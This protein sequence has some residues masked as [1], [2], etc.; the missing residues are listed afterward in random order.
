M[1]ENQPTT[2]SAGSQL[3]RVTSNSR[4]IVT[5]LL[6]GVASWLLYLSLLEVADTLLW[7]PLLERGYASLASL[8]P[9]AIVVVAYATMG[10]WLAAWGIR[11]SWWVLWL[12]FVAGIVICISA[13]ATLQSV[14][15]ETML[16]ISVFSAF[17]TAAVTSGV[18]MLLASRLMITRSNKSR[19]R[20]RE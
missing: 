11:P 12:A 20:T 10:R 17:V 6:S 14:H 1:H 19:E 15:L 5:S 8:L 18:A 4:A 3:E 13:R 7:M 16:G 2:P 9:F